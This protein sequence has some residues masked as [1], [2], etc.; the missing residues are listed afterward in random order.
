MG[1][2]VYELV[3]WCIGGLVAWLVV[4]WVGGL[5][6]WVGWLVGCAQAETFW[7]DLYDHQYG[8]YSAGQKG[9]LGFVMAEYD[10][11]D[12]TGEVDGAWQNACQH[13]ID[14][15]VMLAE[16]DNWPLEKFDYTCA[17]II[18]RHRPD[19]DLESE[20]SE[21]DDTLDEE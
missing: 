7:C 16:A 1:W 18:A 6:G 13:Q 12:F 14:D 3:G 5:V 19:S 20:A 17:P 8:N 9:R 10:N 2:L 11:E 4:W 15:L 21:A